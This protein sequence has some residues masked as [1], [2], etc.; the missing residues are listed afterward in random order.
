[1]KEK[2]SCSCCTYLHGVNLSLYPWMCISFWSINSWIY[3]ESML[4]FILINCNS[5]KKPQVFILIIYCPMRTNYQILIT[6]YKLFIF[7]TELWEHLYIY[8]TRLYGNSCHYFAESARVHLLNDPDKQR[9]FSQIMTILLLSW[10]FS[11]CR[12]SFQSISRVIEQSKS[13]FDV[14]NSKEGP[15]IIFTSYV[16]RCIP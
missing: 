8:F 11:K 13:A 2:K 5:W 10:G 7:V 9:N 16:Q 12:L 14:K 15:P 3:P 1:M 4:C 6:M